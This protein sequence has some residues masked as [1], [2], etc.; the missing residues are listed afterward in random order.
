MKLSMKVAAISL[1]LLMAAAFARAQDQPKLSDDHSTDQAKASDQQNKSHVRLDF[2]FTEYNGDK[3]ISSLP[4]TIYAEAVSRGGPRPGRVRMTDNVPVPQGGDVT[5]ETDIDSQTSVNDDGSY[6]L[7]AVTSQHTVDSATDGQVEP[8]ALPGAGGAR[9][10]NR[11]LWAQFNLKL[12]DGQAAEGLS[13]T[14][15]LNG[16]VLKI[17]VTL[18]VLK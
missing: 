16:H 13:A 4:Y 5:L 11:N 8:N 7:E 6:D 9:P 3:K 2:L 1:C 17:T 18:H 15:P 12:H 10:V 14:N